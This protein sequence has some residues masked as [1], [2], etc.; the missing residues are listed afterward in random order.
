MQE[1]VPRILLMPAA[2][3]VE[4]Y[5]RDYFADEPVLAD[6]AQCE[7]HFK[8]FDKDGSI[9]RGRINKNDL[10]IMQVNEYY[11]GKM[12]ERLGIDLYTIQGNLAYARYLY[13]QKG[14]SPWISSKPCWGKSAEA[15][16][17][18]LKG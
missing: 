11:H 16:K 3:T 18:A 5:T 17:L 4:Q 14:T 8:Q 10:G 7:S 9:H 6:I 13:E 1:D 12:A 15:Q 2:Q